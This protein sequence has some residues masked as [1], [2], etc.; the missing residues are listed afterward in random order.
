M[1]EDKYLK[2]TPLKPSNSGKMKRPKDDTRSIKDFPDKAYDPMKLFSQRL[3][4][5]NDKDMPRSTKREDNVVEENYN[6][7]GPSEDRY[8]KI[9]EFLNKK[10][11]PHKY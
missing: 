2:R 8:S 7:P 6:Y 3:A 11:N 5:N 10:K 9:K 1:A 4:D